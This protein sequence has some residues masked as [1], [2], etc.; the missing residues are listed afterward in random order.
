MWID[1]VLENIGAPHISI[2]F[3]VARIH[4]LYVRGILKHCIVALLELLHRVFCINV[5]RSIAWYILHQ[6]VVKKHRVL[7][8]WHHVHWEPVVKRRDENWVIVELSGHLATGQ[9]FLPQFELL[10]G[11]VDWLAPG[12]LRALAIHIDCHKNVFALL[13]DPAGLMMSVDYALS[14]QHTA[15]IRL[16]PL[17]A[18]FDL[19]IG[20]HFNFGPLVSEVLREV[21]RI[22]PLIENLRVIIDLYGLILSSSGFRSKNLHLVLNQLIHRHTFFRSSLRLWLEAK[23]EAELW[24]I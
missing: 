16:D 13:T 21:D 11:I 17:L 19:F 6:G 24:V 5:K 9:V 22:L 10:L 23:W 7:H 8:D 4:L 2:H 14:A 15:P 3:E 1:Q 18:F 12:M 20:H